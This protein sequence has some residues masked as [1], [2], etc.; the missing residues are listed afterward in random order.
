MKKI[1]L[2]M[3]QIRY[4]FDDE[5]L[6]KQSLTHRSY[7]NENYERMEILGDSILS[8]IVTKW[9][10][11]NHPEASVGQLSRMRASIV[12]NDS[13]AKIA[14]RLNIADF[15]YMGEGEMKSGGFNRPS[16]QADV[17]E[18]IIAAIYLDSSFEQAKEFVLLNFSAE[19]SG[20]SAIS[21]LKDYKTQL[22]EA[23]QKRGMC[24]PEYV[25]VRSFGKDHDKSFVVECKLKGVDLCAKAQAS[26]IKI[27]EQKS[28]EM[29]FNALQK[30]ELVD[31]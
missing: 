23:L 27:A 30:K 31:P 22:Q 19:L 17:L 8:L 28:A 7:S 15:F 13:L 3:E 16:I 20:L 4:R 6:L 2:L 18:S 29:V 26:N 5:S 25:L 21:V 10:F 14:K 9:L 24:L 11:E 12:N 1:S